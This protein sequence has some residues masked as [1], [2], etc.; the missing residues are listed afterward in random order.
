MFP[1][2]KINNHLYKCDLM[3]TKDYIYKIIDYLYNIFKVLL[4]CVI[5]LKSKSSY[6]HINVF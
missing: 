5:E 2:H 1:K 6:R 3:I 4:G